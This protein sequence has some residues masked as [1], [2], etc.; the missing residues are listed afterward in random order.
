MIRRHAFLKSARCGVGRQS[1]A[2]CCVFDCLPSPL[3]R[4]WHEA[5]SAMIVS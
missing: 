3:Q 1:L 2:V 5:A 4:C